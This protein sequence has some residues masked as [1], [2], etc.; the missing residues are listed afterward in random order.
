MVRRDR[1][2]RVGRIYPLAEPPAT[3]ATADRK[4]YDAGSYGAAAG[5][6]AGAV[7]DFGSALAHGD[8]A[9]AASAYVS[10]WGAFFLRREDCWAVLVALAPTAH[11]LP[12]NLVANCDSVLR[13]PFER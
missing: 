6:F 3:L 1:G 4:L 8:L 5:R 10:G 9:G 11:R 13:A 2:E 7:R 12:K